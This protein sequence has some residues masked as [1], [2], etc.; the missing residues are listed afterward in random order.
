MSKRI[1]LSNRHKSRQG[2]VRTKHYQLD[3]KQ[4]KE[5]S[6]RKSVYHIL[7]CYVGTTLGIFHLFIQVIF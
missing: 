3:Y 4:A 6:E 5:V 2:C 7:A 1:S